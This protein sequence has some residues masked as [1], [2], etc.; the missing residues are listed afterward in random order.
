[1]YN[2][3]AKKLCFFQLGVSSF[4]SLALARYKTRHLF[5]YKLYFGFFQTFKDS[6]IYTYTYIYTQTYIYIYIYI[7]IHIYVKY[8][9]IYR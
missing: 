7:H 3:V 4:F 2:I 5:I 6:Y 1:M 9:Y 8:K